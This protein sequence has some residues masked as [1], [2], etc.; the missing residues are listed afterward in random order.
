MEV[1]DLIQ[2]VQTYLPQVDV[3]VIRQAYEFASQAHNG[4][5]RASGEAYVQHP[6]A[7]ALILAGMGLDLAAITA[8]LLHDVPEDTAKPLEEI[9]KGFGEEVARLVDGVTK[10]SRISWG[11]L[12]EEQAENLRKMFLAMA[13][14][15]RVVLIKLAD[16]LHNMRTLD[17][18][19][20]DKQRKIAKET[21]EIYAPLTSRLGIWQMKWE[22]E[23]L[24]FRYLDPQRYHEIA[25]RL[26]SQRKEREAYI[27]RVIDVL[28]HALQQADIEAEL[29]GRPKHIYSI[30]KKMERKG[31]SLD[32]IY[33]LIA[34]RVMVNEVK[35]CYAALGVV[36]SLW[37]PIPGEFDDYIAMPK[38]NLYQS[39]HTAVVALDGLPI[40]IQ[41][42]THDMH[43]VSEYG[44][45]AHWRYKEGSKRDVNF[46]AK[47]AWLRQLME[48]RREIADAREFVESLKTDIFQDQVY[49]F[50]PKGD[51]IDLPAGAT[52]LDFAYRIHTDIG[53]R[54][55]G[56]RVNGRLVSLDYRLQNGERVEIITA[57]AGGPSRDWLN[58]NLGFIKTSHARDKT[59]QWFKRQTRA[60]NIAQGK[61]LLERELK[62]LGLTQDFENLIRVFEDNQ[63]A[64][65]DSIEKAAQRWQDN[66]RQLG[67]T[68]KKIEEL[69]SFCK[70]FTN[71]EDLYLAIGSGDIS[72]PQVSTHLLVL[73]EEKPVELRGVPTV[74]PAKEV[75]GGVQV[76]GE[77]GLLTSLGRCCNP[78]P[79]DE[80]VG[81]VT[82]GQ[83][84]TVHRRDCR[85][86]AAVDDPRRLV[87]VSW[88][89][90]PR[91]V[92][93]VDMVIKATDREG[94]LKDIATV[95]SGEHVNI[96]AVNVALSSDH[97]AT[98]KVTLQ[99]A[100]TEQLSRVLAHIAKTENVL[101]VYCTRRGHIPPA[102]KPTKRPAISTPPIPAIASSN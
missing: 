9:R 23:D 21:M 94:L 33:D 54:C 69:I 75:I 46:E 44:I 12:E 32:Q 79:G 45:A 17:S 40:E 96:A 65:G 39:L 28:R 95:V 38:E 59:R 98:I 22:L 56:A 62:Y 13:E 53:H 72:P 4:Q 26:A 6:L 58:P 14:D 93:P 80:I 10:L 48:W 91:P 11:T 88:G 31:R 37:H 61:E 8:A 90:A 82:R 102:P 25:N 3:Q 87:K 66:L 71:R 85:N 2:K 18:L 86:V 60:E 16:R 19:P 57:K 50:T 24:S 73:E 74:A 49:V 30:H 43:R 47:L 101:E 68:P 20:P 55:R 89:Q 5:R 63:P 78:V 84:V 83:G 52:P 34:I 29:Y 27:A 92:Y 77:P 42:R 36:H 100:S 51:I 41:I 70:Q 35:D 7:A 15:V 67:Y 99:V 1:T 97:I 64:P 81:Y 76:M